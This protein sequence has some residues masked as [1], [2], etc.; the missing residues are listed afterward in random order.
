MIEHIKQHQETY[1]LWIEIGEIVHP[2]HD[3]VSPLVEEFKA[4]FPTV[5]LN[6][7]NECVID[8][9]RW[10]LSKIKTNDDKPSNKN[11]RG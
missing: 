9:L 6:G 11:S 2:A 3:L 4:E 8:M 5:N 10:A 1:R 7:C